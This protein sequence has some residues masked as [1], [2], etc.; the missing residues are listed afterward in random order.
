MSSQ[1]KS[2]TKNPKKRAYSETSDD[3]EPRKKQTKFLLTEAHKNYIRNIFRKTKCTKKNVEDMRK[4][5]E[6]FDWLC[7]M[8]YS[9]KRAVQATT[10][11]EDRTVMALRK[12]VEKK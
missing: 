8:I 7:A 10:S 1:A 4:K 9:A 3:S 11:A 12:I 6:T 5:N 2:H